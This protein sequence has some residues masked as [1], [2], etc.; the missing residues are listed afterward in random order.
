[1]SPELIHQ[2]WSLIERTQTTILL[3]LDDDSLVRCLI[4]AFQAQKPLE[5]EEATLF[6]HYVW[7]HLPLIRDIA[8]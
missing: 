4:R 6:Q 7:Q 3:D 5:G 1:M 2:F 8:Q